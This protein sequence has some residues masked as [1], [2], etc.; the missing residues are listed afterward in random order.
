MRGMFFPKASYPKAVEASAVS[1]MLV[2]GLMAKDWKLVGRM[3]QKTSFTSHTEGRSSLSFRKWSM[4]QA[5][6][7][8]SGRL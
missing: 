2:A 3:M 8:R 7:A 4:K 1:N 5:K 6:T